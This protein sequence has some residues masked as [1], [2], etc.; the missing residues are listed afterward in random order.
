MNIA[1]RELSETSASVGR[2]RL[3]ALTSLR[4]FAAA[5]IVALHAQGHFGIPA[6]TASTYSLGAGVSIFFVLSGFILTYVYPILPTR[7]ETRRFL[8][9]RIARI[10]PAHIASTLFV[11]WLFGWFQ[12]GQ[13]GILLRILANLT[14]TQAWIPLNQIGSI[15]TPSW[16]ISTEFAFYLLFPFLIA[17]FARTWWWKLLGSFALAG[18]MI[19]I[20]SIF[21]LRYGGGSGINGEMLTYVHPFG[22]V[23]EFV[24]GMCAALARRKAKPIHLNIWL[25]TVIEVAAIVL[26]FLSIQHLNPVE[27]SNPLIR[28][29][30]T[31]FEPA[32]PAAILIFVLA[33][34]HGWISR[35]M[36][37]A[38]LVL[39]GE[40]SYSI[41]LF[42]M[43]LLTF[44][45]Q[46]APQTNVPAWAA[47]AI[48]SCVL[49][50][51]SLA[52][53]YFIEQPA[54]NYVKSFSRSRSSPRSTL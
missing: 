34:R 4:F 14:M 50:T 30:Y 33:S 22:R 51:V 43:P 48:F 15:N 25:G 38:W 49:F 31:S 2:P 9:A 7:H 37:A 36:E 17:D 44:Y 24:I 41:Y 42:H 53:W 35:A 39:L 6:D 3:A 23:A 12:L 10:W 8:L 21:S 46:I 32:I 27:V 28:W 29:Y 11:L 54:R 40:I 18:F 26:M 20:T 52:T 45:W 13:E 1:A 47:L 5:M 16:T 19:G